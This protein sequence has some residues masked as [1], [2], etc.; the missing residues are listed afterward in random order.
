M[1]LEILNIFL[2]TQTALSA[3]IVFLAFRNF[4]S[5]E[6]YVRLI[7]LVF[8]LGFLANTT[9]FILYHSGLR[10]FI[11]V[12]QSS[13][14][15]AVLCTISLLYYAALQ[16]RYGKWFLLVTACFLIF[17]LV[18]FIFLQKDAINSYNKFLSSF[19][20]LCYCIFYFYRLMVELPSTHLQRMPMFWFN[21]ALLIYHAGTIF[22]FAFTAYLTDVLKNDLV[23]YWSFHNVLSIIEHILV[24]IGLFYE[25]RAF[26]TRDLTI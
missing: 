18:N 23:T 14:D 13:Y 22:L 12:P 4:K 26:K 17:S 11:N 9:A 16:K 6:N 25:Y 5:R 8:L 24:I 2:Y 19:I 7:G 1:T 10:K 20:V 3:V 15:I 21:S